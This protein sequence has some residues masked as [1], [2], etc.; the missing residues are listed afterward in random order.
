M[1]EPRVRQRAGHRW[2]LSIEE[3]RQLAM[4]RIELQDKHCEVRF[5]G[6][7]LAPQTGAA[8]GDVGLG[9]LSPSPLA[10]ARP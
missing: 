5:E 6:S 10:L 9:P 3:R 8:S 2:S 7:A 4:R 1:Y